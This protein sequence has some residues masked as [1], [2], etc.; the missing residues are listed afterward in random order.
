MGLWDIFLTIGRWAELVSN[1]RWALPTADN[2]HNNIL[3]RWVWEDRSAPDD[4]EPQCLAQWLGQKVGV[5]PDRAHNLLEPYTHR[6]EH[7]VYFSHMAQEA[8]N[9]TFA[10]QARMTILV[11]VGVPCNP[12]V[13]VKHSSTAPP[14][15][16]SKAA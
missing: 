11:T 2:L 15:S 1:D 14:M 10:R 5:T 4:V 8:H 9:K 6:R 12:T 7:D 3:T 16:G 13:T